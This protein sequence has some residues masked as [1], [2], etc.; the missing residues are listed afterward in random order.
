MPNVPKTGY[1]M[2]T[3]LAPQALNA[4]R[5]SASQMYK[6]YVPYA[7]PD[8]E[9]LRAIGAVIMDYPGIQ[10]EFISTLLNRIARVIVTSRSYENPLRAFKKG[11]MEMGETVEEICAGLAKP[12]QYN[13]ENAEETVFKREIPDVKTAFH[14]V[15]YKKFYKT[16]IQMDS[17]RAAFLSWDA[18]NRFIQDVTARMYT[19]MNYDEFVCMKYMLAKAILAGEIKPID[20][21]AIGNDPKS[22]VAKIKAASNKLTFMSDEYNRAGVYNNS[23]KNE[24]IILVSAD[25]DASMDVNVLAAAY[26]LSYAEFIGQRVLIDSFGA[27][28]TARLAELFAGDPDYTEIGADDLAKLDAI[29]AVT[30]DK[31]YFQ[32]YDNLLKFT[33]VYNPQGLYWNWM[34][35]TWKIM[36]ASPFANAVAFVTGA[37]TVTSVTVTPA[38]LSLAKGAAAQ[39][40]VSVVTTNF[41]P[42]SVTWSSNNDKVKVDNRGYV[43]VDATA[44]AGKVNITATSTFDKTKTGKCEITVS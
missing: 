5:N 35:H 15:N 33:E 27:L 4:I 29:P 16:T 24:Q 44:T 1:E 31:N 23:P 26:N 6:N 14:I 39:L 36:S 7:T 30:V 18:M 22:N 37:P 20:I 34:L 21:G 17:L 13:P 42:Q 40:G 10:N 41:A 43:T 12:F 8:A 32:V 28:D 3:N 19:A 2:N 25:F 11:I 38:T 9:S